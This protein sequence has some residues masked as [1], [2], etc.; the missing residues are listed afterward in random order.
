M[1]KPIRL[2]VALCVLV[3]SQAF[4]AVFIVPDDR[5]LV[6]KSS[7]IVIGTV[8]DSAS[9]RGSAGHIETTYSVRIERVLKGVFSRDSIVKVTSPG[10]QIGK[11][12][13]LVPGSAHFAKD[14]RVLLFLTKHR[15]R[16]TPTDMTLG[17]FRFVTST[18]GQSLLLRDGE[19]I[20]GFDKEMRTHVERVRKEKDFLAFVEETVRGGRAEENY[21][22]PPGETVSLPQSEKNP[23]DVSANAFAARSYALLV[24]GSYA[25]RWPNVAEN[26]VPVR[27]SDTV[28]RPFHQSTQQAASGLGDGGVALTT[29]ALNTWMNDCFSY[30]NIPFATNALLLDPGDQTNTI[31]WN[32][33][34]DD[35]P[36]AFGGSGIVAKAFVEADNVISF[37]GD[38]NWAAILD[39]DIVVQDGVTGAEAIMGNVMTHEIGHA[40]GLRHSNEHGDY[41][42]CQVTDECTTSAVMTSQASTQVA[43]QT[44]D[45][46][47]I[48]ALYPIADQCTV[49]APPAPTGL[50]ATATGSTNVTVAWNASQDAT[51]YKV[52]R[53]SGPGSFTQIGTANATVFTDSSANNVVA[54]TAYMYM[55]RASNTGGDSGDSNSDLATTVVF[56]DPNLATGTGIK[57]V[58]FTELRTAVDAVRV[59]AGLAAGT[60][61]D[62]A[63][64]A[65]TTIKR[66]HVID[67][68]SQLDAARS[69]LSLPA[70]SYTD[71]TITAG[72][73][74]AKAAHVTEVRAGTQ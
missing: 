6:G 3:S 1:F 55:V 12:F 39:A 16:W 54:G 31:I 38:P 4:A 15:G 47:A 10:G 27:M 67:L 48:R 23:F 22:V 25:I 36:G 43:L 34:G 62:P 30:V 74:K 7:G 19:D 53:R 45:Q 37:E 42:P 71:G 60:Y 46:T 9:E 66:L 35:I 58:H 50:T 65:G 21:F 63:L 13:T 5:E 44:W 14:D 73:T 51:S 68:R 20:V 32:D 69:I 52:F 2:A 41:T 49:P 40:L 26:S 72:S 33:P 8:V 61:T 29:S 56:T 70:L 11:R 28:A 59:L 57:A 17:K 24:G 18:G 64:A